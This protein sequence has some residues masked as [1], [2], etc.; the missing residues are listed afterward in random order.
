M[1][2][3]LQIHRLLLA[4]I[5]VLSAAGAG[6]CDD[7]DDDDG[8]GTGATCP[9]GSTLTYAS[10]GQQFMTTYCTRCHASTLTGAARMGAP[11]FHDFDTIEGI[12][13][14]ADHIDEQAGAGPDATNVAMPP[15]GSMPT[16]DQRKMLAEWIACQAP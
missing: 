6:G 10:F 13:A 2:H 5:L 11:E 12:R 14:V 4:S 8:A 3:Q 15:T 16:L 7:D 9:P 1:P